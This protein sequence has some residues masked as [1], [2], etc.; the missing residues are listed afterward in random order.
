MMGKRV[1]F[2]GR[3]VISPDPNITTDQIGVPV[4]MARKLT[5]P[6]SVSQVNIDRLRKLVKN[7]AGVHPGANI[8]EDEE[9]GQQYLLAGMSDEDR[10]GIAEQLL[11][12][13]KIVHRH[14]ANGDVL[15]VNRQPTL[16]KPSIMAHLARILPKEQTLRLHYA[17]C[18][19]YNADF[20]GD[21]MNI[22]FPQSYQAASEAYKLMATHKQYVVPTSGKPIRGL[23]QDSVVS[24]VV[25]TSKDS[26]MPREQY[27]QLVYA[28]LRELISEN[29][30]SKVETLAPTII[31]PRALWTGKQVISTILKN[32]V[33]SGLSPKEVKRQKDI[34]GMNLDGKAR[35]NPKEWGPLGKEEG[36]VI[37]RDN[38]HL[39]GTLDKNAF[40]SSDQGM[41]HAFYELYGSQKAGD[42]LTALAR[43]F[44]V[45]LQTQG[46]TVGL[47]DLVLRPEFNKQRRMAI[48]KNHREGVISAAKFAGLKDTFKF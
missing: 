24:G 35:L 25:L 3:S 18:S 47:D 48:E 5:F 44:A 36:E 12:G 46:L 23:I 43:I 33:L 28:G 15:L 4:F 26:F 17:N 42:L 2:G 37:I 6:E 13:R 38:E 21:E 8:V 10:E 29:K 11:L 9:S 16:H 1:N 45:M 20:D 19:T 22:H 30:L 41:V 27:M 31:K 7:G 39:Q 34:C 40:G 14:L 32:I